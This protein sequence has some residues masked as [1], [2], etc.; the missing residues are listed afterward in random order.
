MKRMC[1]NCRKAHEMFPSSECVY[2]WC[3]ENMMAISR[4]SQ[5][6][7]WEE[8]EDGEGGEVDGED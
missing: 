6:E 5:E 8:R 4:Y 1:D 7:C 3:H 2:V